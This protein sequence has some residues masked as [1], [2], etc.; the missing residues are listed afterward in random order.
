MRIR[1][2]LQPTL[3]AL[4]TLTAGAAYGQ[5]DTSQALLDLL[6]KKGIVTAQEAQSLKEQAAAQAAASNQAATTSPAAGN[7]TAAAT[8]ARAIPDNAIVTSPPGKSPLALKLGSTTFTPVGFMDL[9]AVH[10]SALNGGDIGSSFASFPY[11]NTANKQLSETRLSAKNSRLGMRIDSGFDDVKLLGYFETDFLGNQPTNIN[12]ASNSDTMRLRVYFVDVQKD[13]WELMAGQDWSMLTPNRK[14]LSP[15]PSDIFYTQDVDTN[16]QVGLVWERTPQV[17]AVYHA[18]DEL[19]LGLALENPDQ[20]VGSVTTLPPAFTATQVDNG[21]NGTATPNV[22]PDIIGKIAYDTK[23]GDLPFHAEAAGLYREFKINTYVPAS[24]INSDA[25]KSGYGGS[26][27]ASIG[28]LPNL[29]LFE[30]AYVSQGGGREISTGVAPDFIVTAPDA[31]GVYHI[32][33]VESN[34]E[35]FGAEYDAT[36]KTKVFGYYG[37]VHIDNAYSR[38]AN[39]TYVGYGYPGSSNA[40]NKNIEEYTLGVSQTLWK[41]AAYGDLKLMLQYSYLDRDPWVVAANTPKD[42]HMNIFYANLRYD[43]P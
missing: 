20:Y 43:L 23:V 19:A 8:P 10:R 6:V 3:L 41:G 37:R 32:K 15:L 17:R 24:N 9:T 1:T 13:Q 25:S 26:F 33:T 36:P 28:V 42:A 31:S 4:A 39:G 16:Y 38:L 34:A 29:Q 35:I 18:S 22:I 12:V 5:Q 40:A 27:N 21:S 30:N 14:G 11:D 2:R 7:T